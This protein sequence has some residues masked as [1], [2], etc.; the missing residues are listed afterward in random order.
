[1]D[2]VRT[3]KS[4]VAVF[5]ATGHTGRFVIAELMRRGVTPVAIARDAAA[6][7]EA[8]FPEPDVLRRMPP[9][10]MQRR[11]IGHFTELKP[12]STARGLSSTRPTLSRAQ[13]CEP[14][15]TIWMSAPSK[16][17]QKRRWRNSMSLL[18]RRG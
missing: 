15:S 17:V 10:T 1:M 3:T 12:P 6:L 13:P 9:S 14:G 7:A 18:A 5:G 8:T 11:S 4:V 16:G 2:K